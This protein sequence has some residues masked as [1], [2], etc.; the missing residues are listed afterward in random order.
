MGIIIQ[1]NTDEEN[2]INIEFHDSATH[3][4]M[5]VTNTHNHTMAALSTEAALLACESDEDSPRWEVKLIWVG[6]HQG[7]RSNWSGSEV[8]W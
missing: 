5:H 2:S 4:A 6:G 3:H 8:N 7:E 1:Y